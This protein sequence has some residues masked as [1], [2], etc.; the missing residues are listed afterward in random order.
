MTKNWKA[1]SW[2]RKGQRKKKAVQSGSVRADFSSQ[3]HSGCRSYNQSVQSTHS[4]VQLPRRLFS[5]TFSL[6]VFSKPLLALWCVYCAHT[7]WCTPQMEKQLH[8]LSTTTPPPLSIHSFLSPFSCCNLL[9][10]KSLQ[11]PVRFQVTLAHRSIVFKVSKSPNISSQTA[12]SAS[13]L[14]R[15]PEN[16]ND[17]IW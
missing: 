3:S 6:V 16:Q 1:K 17:L 8:F 15:M 5:I 11:H 13:V 10:L 4:N 2:S 12:F 14:H 9:H 7:L